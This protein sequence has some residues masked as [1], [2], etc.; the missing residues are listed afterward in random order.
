MGG[1]KRLPDSV[2]KM[3]G[4]DQPC[5]MSPDQV[6]YEK[7]T[8]IPSAPSY[9]NSEGKKVYKVTA[10][11]LASIGILDV[12]NIN[13][14]VLYAS[15]MGKYIQALK[16]LKKLHKMEFDNMKLQSCLEYTVDHMGRPGIARTK[17]DK[18]ATEYLDN[19]RKLATELGITPASASKVKLPPK[20]EEDPL[21]KLMKEFS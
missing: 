15:E 19:A 4:T 5:R 6:E 3:K 18:M 13:T 12:V 10:G 8:E 20:K 14:V 7:I 16:D 11:Q 17:L 1:R 2:K 9:L 21:E